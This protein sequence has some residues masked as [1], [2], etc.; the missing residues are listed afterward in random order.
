MILR[1]IALG[2]I[3]S[4]SN[5]AAAMPIISQVIAAATQASDIIDMV[6]DDVAKLPVSPELKSKLDK[7]IA[8][9]RLALVAAYEAANGANDISKADADAAFKRFRAA[10]AAL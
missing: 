5:C 4:L 7:A 10:W 3:L 2:L 1:A 9:C 8:D 6:A